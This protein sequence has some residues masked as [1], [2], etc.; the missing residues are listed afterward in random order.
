MNKKKFER[1]REI[2]PPPISSGDGYLISRIRS[3]FFGRIYTK[4][5][6][7]YSTIRWLAILIWSS[8]YPI[9]LR[10]IVSPIIFLR[11]YFDKDKRCQLRWR[12]LVRQSEFVA[13]IAAP[14]HMLSGVSEVKTPFPLA[15]PET[16]RGC[17]VAPHE[18]YLFP[19]IFVSEVSEAMVFGGSNLVFTGNVVLCHDLY[20]FPRDSTSEELHGR[21]LIDAKNGRVRWLLHD[22]A[23]EKISSAAVF[24]DAC[25]SNYAHWLTEVLPRIAMFCAE[26]KFARVPL[27]VDAGLHYNLMESLLFTAGGDREIICLPIGRAISV[28]CLYITSTCGYVPFGR[29][30]TKMTGH[31]HGVFSPVAFENVRV[32]LINLAQQSGGGELPKKIY[33]RRTSG[34]RKVTNVAEIENLLVLRGFSI[35]EP[36]KLSFLEQVRLFANADIIFGSSGAALA[37]IIFCR[38]GTEINIFISVFADTSYWYWQNI[39]CAIGCGVNYYF[40]KTLDN[41]RFGIHSDFQVDPIVIKKK[42]DA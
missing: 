1:V 19:E 7:Q 5:L 37:N 16:E 34:T 38:P 23:P 8:G 17:L 39:A 29:R 18:W 11:L 31:S 12:E 14:S 15:F 21:A 6:K 42:F 25:A 36:E 26:K 9:F 40:G 13:R 20:D 24:T 33:I 41:S 27:I 35:I 28:D 32:K 3:S 22:Q 10:C 4:Y 30:N 2:G